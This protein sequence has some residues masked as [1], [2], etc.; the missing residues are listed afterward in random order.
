MS[1]VRKH[2]S[3]YFHSVWHISICPHKTQSAWESYKG[4]YHTHSLQTEHL[5]LTSVENTNP[6]WFSKWQVRRFASFS[7]KLLS[8]SNR[9]MFWF[10]AWVSALGYRNPCVTLQKETHQT[11]WQCNHLSRPD[12]LRFWGGFITRQPYTLLMLLNAFEANTVLEMRSC[13]QIENRTWGEW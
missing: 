9:K 6:A 12:N 10:S 8:N 11:G 13:R 3:G 4:H 2:T 1:E 5:C 7:P